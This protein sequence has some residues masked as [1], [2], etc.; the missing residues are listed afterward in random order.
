[1]EYPS[2]KSYAYSCPSTLQQ[3]SAAAHGILESIRE[4]VEEHH[5][6]FACTGDEGSTHCKEVIS[7]QCPMSTSIENPV[8]GTD[9][10]IHLDS[11]TGTFVKDD[12]ANSNMSGEED[13]EYFIFAGRGD[14]EDHDD[15]MDFIS[16][17]TIIPDPYDRVYQNIPDSTH[18]LA[19]KPDCKH[20]G[21]KRFQY[22]PDGFCCRSG[23]IK[24]AHSESP[25][26]L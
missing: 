2:L 26:E 21:A 25:L 5:N 11:S 22:E 16:A 13:E 10:S 17:E 12:D 15:Q 1:M 8:S 4:E 14:D 7:M 6:A 23:K 24:L 9:D 18:M 20:C 3:T 19:T